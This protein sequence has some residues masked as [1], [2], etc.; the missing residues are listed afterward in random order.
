MGYRDED[1][2]L[3]ARV[4]HLE[5]ELEA[6]QAELARLRG[7]ESASF[8]APNA[9][10]G[11]PTRLG[12]EREIPFELDE[13]GFEELVSILRAELG[14]LGRLDRV[15]G[16]LTWAT[17]YS[18]NQGGR[19][20]EVSMERRRGKTRVVVREHLGQLAGGL[21]GG[22]VGGLGGGGLGALI[23]LTIAGG[24]AAPWV[25]LLAVGWV[26][27]TWS[28]VRL[29]YGALA[30]RRAGDH[31]RIARRIDEVLAARAPSPKA[32]VAVDDEAEE[33]HLDEPARTSDARKKEA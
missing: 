24:I 23:P 25:P 19:R 20:V 5:T 33:H 18:R 17:S 8:G 16:T 3:R 12:F 11:G 7:G 13:E 10:L 22:I 21:F 14:E 28:G 9:W 6:T 4:A 32:R 31:A 26:G 15:G 30:R 1:E 2:A 27:V 29:G